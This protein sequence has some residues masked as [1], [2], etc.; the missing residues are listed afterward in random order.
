MGGLNASK[1]ASASS[2]RMR[3]GFVP[4]SICSNYMSTV[5]DRRYVRGAPRKNVPNEA[6]LDQ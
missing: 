3:Q 4:D 6:T 2:R 1:N 5:I